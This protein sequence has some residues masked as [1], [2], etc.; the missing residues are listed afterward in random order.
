MEEILTIIAANYT[1]IIFFI[2]FPEL[3]FN[4]YLY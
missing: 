1:Q 3:I 4:L 2:Y